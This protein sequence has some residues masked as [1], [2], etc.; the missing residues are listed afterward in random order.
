MT[1]H[2]HSHVLPVIVEGNNEIE[3]IDE[4]DI[5]IVQIQ[6]RRS[7]NLPK[8]IHA[9][10]DKLIDL[11]EE[12]RVLNHDN[13]A[14]MFSMLFSLEERIEKKLTNLTNEVLEKLDSESADKP[15]N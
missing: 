1:D 12:M 8:N 9:R 14:I 6:R 3:E 15:I 11:V 13:Q 2:H 10:M 7:N 4:D 5:D